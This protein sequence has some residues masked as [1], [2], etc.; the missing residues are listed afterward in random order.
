MR[1]R[2]AEDKKDS[3]VGDW[4]NAVWSDETIS[5]TMG[6][7]FWILEHV[8]ET[9]S[10]VWKWLHHALGTHALGRRWKDGSGRGEHE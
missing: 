10:Q 1:C 4:E 2:F 6:Q 8:S 9:N 3:T 5:C 7:S